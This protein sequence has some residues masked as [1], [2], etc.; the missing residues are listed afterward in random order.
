MPY[1]LAVSGCIWLVPV[2]SS[3]NGRLERLCWL[4]PQVRKQQV[5]QACWAFCSKIAEGLADFGEILDFICKTLRTRQLCTHC[6]GN[7]QLYSL[8]P[9]TWLVFLFFNWKPRLRQDKSETCCFEELRVWL[10]DDYYCRTEYSG[11]GMNKNG[12]IV[13]QK[14][15]KFYLCSIGSKTDESYQHPMV[16]TA[17]KSRNVPYFIV[18]AECNTAYLLSWN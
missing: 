3:E 4:T 1:L 5:W 15:P 8:L 2:L 14:W 6:Y 17:P 16:D 11:S 12:Q 10:G 7:R 13:A 9:N 18:K